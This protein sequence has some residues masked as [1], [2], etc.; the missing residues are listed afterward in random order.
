MDYILEISGIGRNRFFEL[1][2]KYRKDP[3]DF[4]ISYKRRRS[5]RRIS[6]EIEENISKEPCLEKGL[7]EN[8]DMPNL[9]LYNLPSIFFCLSAFS[10]IRVGNLLG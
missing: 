3:E 6:P 10:C 1:L 8:E 4:S 7:I 2:K 9:D 5:C